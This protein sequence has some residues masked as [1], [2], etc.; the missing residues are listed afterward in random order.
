MVLDPAG[1]EGWSFE[2][3]RDNFDARIHQ[4]P[5]FR[6][7]LHEDPTGFS[8]PWMADDPEFDIDNHINRIAVAPPGTDAD[9]T[10]LVGTLIAE[11][12]DRSRPLWEA[13][14]I[15]GLEGGRVGMLT[16]VHHAI[17]DGASGADLATVLMDMEANPDPDPEPPPYEP[18]PLPT[19]WERTTGGI[20]Q[21]LEYPV[22]FARLGWQAVDMGR[23]LVKGFLDDAAPS[24]PFSAPRTPFNGRL[25]SERSLAWQS[26]PMA[27]VTRIKEAFG[28]KTNDVVLAIVGGTLRRYLEE[29]DA[30]P[31]KPLVAQVP[32]SMRTDAT[33][34]KVGTQVAAMFTSLATDVDDTATRLQTIAAE[35]LKAKAMRREFDRAHQANITESVTPAVIRTAARMWTAAGLDE[36]TPPVFNLIVSNVAG[37]QFELYMAGARLEAMYPLGPLLYGSGVNATV[38]SNADRLDVGFL[39][40]PDLVPDVWSIAAHVEPALAELSEA[41]G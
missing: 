1:G 24:Q 41:A 14:V 29:L 34:E 27:E 40:C 30:L 35:T 11:K 12:L 4:S 23:S 3:L 32:V 25:T 22:K 9:L 38:I 20:G 19:A 10:D 31:G 39:A 26:L 2:R 18:E 17:I 5:Q 33:R 7:K 21:V 36:R 37:P 16:K 15:E 13:W 6:W 8:R 28:V